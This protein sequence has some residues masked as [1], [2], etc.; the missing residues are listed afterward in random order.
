MTYT[1]TGIDIEK[2]LSC[3]YIV[4][5]RNGILTDITNKHSFNNFIIFDFQITDNGSIRNFYKLRFSP[6]ELL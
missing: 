2:E 1:R 5:K 3:Q 6:N 4:R